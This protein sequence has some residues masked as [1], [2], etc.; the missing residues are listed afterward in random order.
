MLDLSQ[1]N[2]STWFSSTPVSDL[3]LAHSSYRGNRERTYANYVLSSINRPM[4]DTH[5]A[6]LA[7]VTGAEDNASVLQNTHS[8]Q[9][10]PL[11]SSQTPLPSTNR[12][13]TGMSGHDPQYDLCLIYDGTSTG[14]FYNG[15]DL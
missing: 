7:Q 10:F 4:L 9:P 15:Y 3:L 8:N 11:G 1:P 12:I 5:L 2:S 6:P 13:L 14:I